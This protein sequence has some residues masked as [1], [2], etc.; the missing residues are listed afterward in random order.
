MVGGD[1]IIF[2]PS[3]KRIR[4]VESGGYTMDT[5]PV[6]NNDKETVLESYSRYTEFI[7][8]SLVNS[9]PLGIVQSP[10][11]SSLL[12]SAEGQTIYHNPNGILAIGTFS[13]RYR[14]SVS[15]RSFTGTSSSNSM[16]FT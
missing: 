6:V 16:Y 15:E 3:T 7:E 2:E 12:A 13:C 14:S 5:C 11:V 10:V 9:I 8:G 1:S 4:R